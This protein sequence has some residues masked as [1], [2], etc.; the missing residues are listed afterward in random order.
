[1]SAPL[2]VLHL[3]NRWE[4]GG[5][6]EHVRTL[7][8]ALR[9]C[10]CDARVAAWIAPQEDDRDEV[11]RLPLYSQAGGRKSPTGFLASIGLLRRFLLRERIAVLHLHSRYVTALGAFAIAG[12]AVARVYTAHSAFRDLGALPWYPRDIICPGHA[13]RDAFLDSVRGA[14]RHR[15]HI[16]PHGVRLPG[17]DA[18]ERPANMPADPC[19]LFLGRLAPGKGGDVFIDALAELRARGSDSWSALFVGD[20]PCLD[21]W[22]ARAAARGVSDAVRFAGHRHHPHPYLAHAR[23]LVLPSTALEGLPMAMLE[24]MAAGCPVIAS[25]LAPFSGTLENG[26]TGLLFRNGD[27]SALAALLRDALTDARAMTAMAARARRTVAERHTV[28]Q[29]TALTLDVYHAAMSNRD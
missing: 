20:G 25:D 15:L 1:M 28:E 24:A 21:E 6:R 3:V 22:R 19:L 27:S 13:V 17:D 16:V 29:M 23:A 7:N 18:V 2:R 4:R 12:T 14:D 10:G 26:A 8:S 9:E 11:F 5:V